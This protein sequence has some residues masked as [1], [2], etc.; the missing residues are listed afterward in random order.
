M[1]GGGVIHDVKGIGGVA[2]RARVARAVIGLMVVVGISGMSWSAARMSEAGLQN[3]PVTAG[4]T[5]AE[6][7]DASTCGGAEHIRG[8]P[9]QG[10]NLCS[11][12]AVELVLDP[13]RLFGL[14]SFFFLKFKQQ[15]NTSSLSSVPMYTRWSK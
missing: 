7:L 15:S 11:E 10:L 3:P 4:D 6:E 14:R 8:A 2:V 9:S 1:S 13:Q 12:V 5:E